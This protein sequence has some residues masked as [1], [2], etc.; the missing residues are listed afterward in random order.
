M[1]GLAS[2]HLDQVPL[3]AITGQVEQQS[4]FKHGFQRIDV[5]GM[6]APLSW[7]LTWLIVIM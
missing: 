4:S 5:V 7:C 2:A 6:F 1:T 3:I